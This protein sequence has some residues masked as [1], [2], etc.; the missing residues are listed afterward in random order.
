MSGERG[1][2]GGRADPSVRKGEFFFAKVL[3]GRG[4]SIFPGHLHSPLGLD[5]PGGGDHLHRLGDLLDVPRRGNT[6]LDY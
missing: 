1:Q 4:L 5:E 6:K 2:I 3:T